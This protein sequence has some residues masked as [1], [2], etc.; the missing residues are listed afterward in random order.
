MSEELRL[1]SPTD[2][3]PEATQIELDGIERHRAHF[4]VAFPGANRA[5]LLPLQLKYLQR[6]LNGFEQPG[7]R[8]TLAR[9][10]RI[11]RTRSSVP[12][13]GDSTSQIQS[14][15]MSKAT[16]SSATCGM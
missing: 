16:S 1:R 10:H 14:G 13:A 5:P 15:A 9:V 3:C 4:H 2:V 12:V 6:A 11:L 7:K 8:D